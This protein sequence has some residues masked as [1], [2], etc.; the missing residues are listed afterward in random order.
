MT[1]YKTY[2]NL[3]LSQTAKDVQK[4]WDENKTFEKS[5][6]SREGKTPFVFYEGPPSANGLPGIHHV[7]A[8][9][10][11]D[12]FCRYKTQKGFQVKR[13]AG[14][15][16]HGLPVELGVEKAL[17]ITKEDIG[18][19]ITVEQ[20]NL[21]C[22][23]DV[24]K[25]TDVWED[26]TRKM[27]YWVD[28]K[29]PYITYD[30]KYIESVWWLLNNLYDKGMLY[31]G[32]TIQPYSPAA[33]TGLSSHELNQ[34]GC[35]RDVKDRTAVAM[36]HLSP[37]LSKG[38]GALEVLKKSLSA[39]EINNVYF[40]AWTTTPWTLP[41]NTALAV[42]KNIDYVLVKTFN[43]FSHA[44][45]YVILAKELLGKHFPEKNKE[46]KFEDYKAGDKAIPF[47]IVTEFKGS[48]LAGL[49]YEQLLPFEANKMV[50][51]DGQLLPFGEAGGAV[52]IGDFV[53]TEDGTGIVHIAPS[54]G[55]DDFRVAKQNGIGSLTLVDKR[56]KFLPEIKDGVF[57]YGEEY[58][59]EAY[60]SES[61]KEEQLKIQKEKLK[62]VISDTS[63]L[64][65][66]SVDER[67][68]LKLQEEGKLFKKETYEHSYPHCW[69][70]DKPVL[71]YPLDSWFIKTTAYKERLIELNKNINWKPESTGTGRFGNWLENLND[72]NLSRSR[73]W[74]IPIPIWTEASPDPSKGGDAEQL[75]I[76]SV[77]QLYTEIEK[78]VAAGF[79]KKNPLKDFK[80]G[81]FTS[82]NYQ[83][84]DLHKPYADEIILVSSNGNKMF[85][86]PDLIDVWFDS[87][88]M[89]YAQ[90]HY[91]FENKELI[92]GPSPTL[93]K[94]KGVAPNYQTARKSSYKLLKE[95]KDLNKKEQTEC[96]TILWNHLKGKQLEKFKFRRQHIIDEFI[97]DFVCLSKSLVIEV[98]GGYHLNPEV[99][100]AD[101][102]RTEILESLGYKVIRFTNE[103]VIGSIDSVLSKIKR[104]L[105]ALPTLPFGEGK[106]GAYFP[107]D[108]I[109]E[110]VDQTRGWFFTL[111]A[112]ATMCFDSVAFKNVVSNG[113]VLDKNGQKMSKRLGNAIDPFETIEKYGPD[114]TRWYMITNAAPWDNLKFDLEG[115]AEVQR[116]FFGTLHNTYSFFALYANVDGFNY[117]ETDV[118]MN[119]RPEIDRWILSELNT[120]IKKVDEAYNDY[121]PHRA[122]RLI[123]DFVDEHLSNW[124]VRLCRR[125]FWKGEYSTD[126][127]AAYQTLYR[128]LEVIAQLSA[129]IAPFFMDR[130]FSDL[131]AVTK[132]NNAE[133]IHLSDFPVA[134]EKQ[135]DKNLEERMELAQKISSMVLSVR[136][137]ENI[138]V[139]QPL[140]TIQI[141]VLDDSI[142]SKIEAVKD[143]ILSE[144]N[145]KAI[146]FVSEADTQIVK[147]LKLNFKTL[148]KKCGKHMKAVQAFANENA[149]AIISGIEKAGTFEIKID[150]DSIILEAEDVEIIPVDIPGWKVANSGQLTVA[151]DVTITPELKEEGIARELVNRIQNLR[152]DSNLEL[153]DRIDVKIQRNSAIN[154]A[155][156]NNLDYICAE[157]LA[158]SLELVDNVD[159]TKGSEI[160]LEEE[161]KTLITITKLLN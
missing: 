57:L 73:F 160:E 82:E 101:K 46:L 62:G 138:R 64:K 83:T 129:P 67:I 105:D 49:K 107:A 145:V 84:F 76:G 53:T 146:E 78:S 10:I 23:K 127:I 148:G 7:M 11:K 56:G 38:E 104:E 9:S 97:V 50:E 141:P 55:A 98:D 15:D 43:P 140:K 24:M 151:L 63:K 31:K 79:M 144:V 111:H 89:P 32:Y 77:E 153:T 106:D 87:G 155:I 12:I 91:P 128:C 154:S 81:D 51:R 80:A 35:Y 103:E 65:Y 72:W 16:T 27:G 42:G 34:P 94:G 121:E 8:R 114:A 69:R 58:V 133:S 22:R 126:K 30:N 116:K 75:C 152:K 93:P 131:N 47:E 123:E 85:R 142:K 118:P 18:T 139:R 2:N 149:N 125:R 5:V 1:A 25:Y 122:G 13:K 66:L 90:L 60:L 156:N 132:R 92:D 113:L 137:K 161:V 143:L 26:V 44:I 54:F 95:L 36:F 74:G 157:I 110:G 112:I 119:E 29:N 41:S 20:Y 3:N 102:L 33:G 108:F 100:E 88:A 70:T 99:Q 71:Y 158:S 134:D 115:I 135:I 96:E 40:L 21:E 19:K 37:T 6:T 147:N 130:L 17:G 117:N 150:S 120:L 59:K 28:M 86:E 136:K 45:V 52:I 68:V 124:Y 48:D 4:T 159:A 109:A 39:E 14:W 61:E